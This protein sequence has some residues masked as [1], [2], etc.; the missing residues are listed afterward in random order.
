[1]TPKRTI[2]PLRVLL[3]VSIGTGLSLIGDA[4]LYAVLPTHMADAGIALGM[5]GIILSANRFIRLVLNGPAG[6]AYDRFLKRPLFLLSLLL[7]AI[8]T[9]IYALGGGFY[10]LLAGRLLWGLSWSGIWVGGN[11]MILDISGPGNRG[12]YVGLYNICFFLGTASGSVLGGLL[13]DGLGYHSAMGIGAGLT[14][15]GAVIAWIFLPETSQVKRDRVAQSGECLPAP[16]SGSKRS[17]AA[18]FLLLGVNRLCVAGTLMPTLGLFLFEK[19]GS[20]IEVGG[21]TLGVSSA[22]G[23]GLGMTYLISMGSAPLMG[24]I[25]DGLESRWKAV[26]WGL[27]PGAAGFALVSVGHQAYIVSGLLLIAFAAGSNQGLSIA[28]AGDLSAEDCRGRRMGLLFT[29]GDLA[30]AVA[31]VAAYALIPHSGLRTIY[32]GLA[33]LFAGMLLLAR[34]S[35]RN[36]E[37][38]K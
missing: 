2:T 4:S 3:P 27:L 25:S 28:I 19:F 22:T 29:T 32:L 20:T 33:A 15:T 14:F 11:A 23:I 1:M 17:L 24:R 7:G 10:P 35:A 6:L 8:S 16:D 31:P 38:R 30:S 18:A 21:I 37:S 13:T 26:F 36:E 9:G 5:V 12:R 34:Q